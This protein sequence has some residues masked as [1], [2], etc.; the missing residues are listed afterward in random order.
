MPEFCRENYE[1]WRKDVVDWVEANSGFGK[2]LC[3]TCL[4]F[5]R[6]HMQFLIS[7]RGCSTCG[8]ASQHDK[9]INLR[10]QKLDDWL[11]WQMR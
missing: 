4:G 5:Q 9:I 10:P 7:P 3:R 8:I 2:S 1:R 11:V 6:A